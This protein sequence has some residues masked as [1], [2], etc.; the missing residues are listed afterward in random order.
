MEKIISKPYERLRNNI[1]E[2]GFLLGEVLIEQEGIK[3]Y[4]KVEKLRAL[5]KELRSQNKGNSSRKIRALI[6]RLSLKESYSII[7][8]FSIYFI[9]VNA[10]DEVNRIIKHKTGDESGIDSEDFYGNSFKEIKQLKLSNNQIERIL[11]SIEITPVFTAHPTE[12]VRQTILRK[13]LKISNLLLNKEL[14]YHTD[15]GLEKLKEEIK[16]QITVLWQTNEIRFYKISVEDE[17]INGLFFFKKVFYEIL[18]DFYNDLSKALKYYLNYSSDVPAI[19]KFG[20]WIG[21]DRDGHPYVTEEITK[22][23][24]EIHRK[25][26]INLY[27]QELNKIYE[28]L[29]TSVR[30]K[31]ANRKLIKSIV[32][33]E[34]E[35]GIN[36]SD[37]KLR[38][39]SEI[40]RSKL[41][42]IYKKL[43]NTL[44]EGE[45]GY[46]NAGELMDDLDLITESLNA[47]EGKLIVENFV[48][49]FKI[50]VKTFGFHFVK[51]DIRQ[52]ADLLR[53]TIAEILQNSDPS[54]GY[55]KLSEKEKTELISKEI[56]NPRPLTNRF[57]KITDSSRRIINEFGLI[58]WA[59]R[60]ISVDSAG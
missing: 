20:S 47:N 34:R 58:L 51:L 38:E 59:K 16:T 57:S 30:V 8:A 40:Y 14:N 37:T 7:R 24:F 6:K 19:L 49:P 44:I 55:S 10:A 32:K 42:L 13:I 46:K 2:L 33:E 48:N 3:L 35:L 12:A 29:S 17:I 53:E 21:G 54:I 23:A 39:K 56:L 52:H 9:L 22:Q 25:E 36:P 4:D 60:D 31:G 43:E 5:T 28:E 1:K 15:E 27:T 11:G 41:H 50:K 45:Y 18:P 26:I